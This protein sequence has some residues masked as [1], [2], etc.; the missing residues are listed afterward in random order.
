MIS[1]RSVVSLAAAVLFPLFITVVFATNDQKFSCS[2]SN[3]QSICS[4]ATTCGS[5]TTPCKLDIKRG[6]TNTATATP[7]IPDAKGNKPFCVKVGT[8]I[9]FYTSSKDT[10]FVIDFGSNSPFDPG[11][12]IMGGADRP[13]TVVAKRVGCYKYSVGA[14][15][16][17]SIYG[18]CGNSDTELVIS[19]N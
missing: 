1:L 12:T 9:T 6:A 2:E 8:S 14:C 5:P 10:G 3:P 15:T 16:A 13:V 18:M 7:E 11:G 4:A 19:A 17:G